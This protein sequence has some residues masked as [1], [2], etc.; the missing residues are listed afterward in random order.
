MISKRIFACLLIVVMTAAMTAGAQSPNSSLGLEGSWNTT[1]VFDQPGLP[2]CAPAPSIAIAI[3]PQRGTIIADSCY[4]SESVGYGSWI[5]TANN[6]YAVTF[7]GNSFAPDGTVA[8][9]YKVRATLS[10]GATGDTFAGPFQ[11]QIFDLAGHLLD[12]LTGRVSGVR[13]VV[14]P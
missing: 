1:I 7:I 4:S 13:I 2:P 5:R 6:Q 3:T 8:T 9:S 12:T 10:V 14:E 11:T